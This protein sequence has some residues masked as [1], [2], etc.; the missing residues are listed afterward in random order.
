[1]APKRVFGLALEEALGTHEGPAIHA[2]NVY[3]GAADQ[4]DC[5]EI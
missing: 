2:P 4:T 5:S 3:R 1:L